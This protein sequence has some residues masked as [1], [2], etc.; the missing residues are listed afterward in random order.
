MRVYSIM[1]GR[2]GSLRDRHT[3]IAGFEANMAI[4][5]GLADDASR[6]GLP[7]Q[8]AS[9]MAIVRISGEI[10]KSASPMAQK[11]FG[12][13]SSFDVKQAVRAAARDDD[14]KTIIM[15]VDS[16]GGSVD[17]LAEL[18]DEVREA[19]KV[20]PVIAQVDGL[21]ASAGYYA[22]AHATQIRAQRM[23]MVGSIGTFLVLDDLSKMAE[24]LG[25]EVVVAKTGP[26]KG[27]GVEGT[28]LTD[29]HRAEMQRLVNEYFADFQRTVMAGRN[30]TQDRFDAIATGGVWVGPETLK[31]GLVD[32]LATLE[33]TLREFAV[34]PAASR[35]AVARATMMSMKIDASQRRR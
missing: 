24:N 16:P 18:G 26:L 6:R 4:K 17:G 32:R 29:E 21:A 9:G 14:V 7:L 15:V 12:L 1:P 3:Q 8:V 31:V 10:M 34:A 13:S 5:D 27:M 25:I 28:P 20:K 35:R 11:V 23:D 33:D 2:L 22:I 19:A 30:M